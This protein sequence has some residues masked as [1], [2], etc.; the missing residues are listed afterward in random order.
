[1][2][3]CNFMP[4]WWI[5][6]RVHQWNPCLIQLVI[7]LFSAFICEIRGCFAFLLSHSSPKCRLGHV[8]C[9]KGTTGVALASRRRD[10]RVKGSSGW[11]EAIKIVLFPHSLPGDYYT[12]LAHSILPTSTK[13]SWSQHVELLLVTN[14]YVSQGNLK[15]L[16]PS[17][18]THSH[19]SEDPTW[20]GSFW[21]FEGA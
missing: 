14:N 21:L 3:K 5:R 12:T 16:Q 15:S 9:H 10:G 2:S 11:S 6:I 13:L 8:A 17:A 7:D 20:C 18:A 4:P 1:M 19:Q